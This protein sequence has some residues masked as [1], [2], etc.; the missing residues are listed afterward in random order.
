M[1]L[2]STVSPVLSISEQFIRRFEVPNDGPK[3]LGPGASLVAEKVKNLAQ[4]RRLRLHPWVR[5][6]PKRRERLPTLVLL[7]GEFHGQRSL[8]G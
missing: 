2:N 3:A 6:I 7:L 5:K 8:M 4:C 1:S